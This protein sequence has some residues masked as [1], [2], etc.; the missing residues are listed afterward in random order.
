MSETGNVR[1]ER[2]TKRHKSDSSDCSSQSNSASSSSPHSGAEPPPT[3]FSEPVARQLSATFAADGGSARNSISS[4]PT[5]A[6]SIKFPQPGAG[7]FCP[8]RRGCR[9]FPSRR[10][11][12]S[13]GSHIGSQVAQVGPGCVGRHESMPDCVAGC[14]GRHKSMPERVRAV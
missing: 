13:A 8:R 11:W 7:L 12:Q 2:K 1:P 6:R 5:S 14:V 4:Q 10:R 3:S 9:P